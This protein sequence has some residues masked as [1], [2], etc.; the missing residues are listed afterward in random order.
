MVSR[1]SSDYW[2]GLY[3]QF[4]HT[5]DVS[6]AFRSAVKLGE[7]QNCLRNSMLPRSVK[8]GLELKI[9]EGLSYIAAPESLQSELIERLSKLQR[10]VGTGTKFTYE[11]IVIIIS[12]RIQVDLVLG[13]PSIG[14]QVDRPMIE[15]I[16]DAIRTL[17]TAPENQSAFRAAKKSVGKNWGSPIRHWLLD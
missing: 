5:T 4:L 1:T 13:L 15:R 12:Q 14:L 11:E 10:I 8:V 9:D 2:E 6:T 16:D 17:S 3:E 7:I